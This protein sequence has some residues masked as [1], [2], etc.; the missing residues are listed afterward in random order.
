MAKPGIDVT[1]KVEFGN[2]NDDEYL[3]IKKCL[4]GKE[5]E[6]QEHMI[7][8]YPYNIGCPNCGVKLFFRHV[9]RIYQEDK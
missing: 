1:D 9:V 7:S 3:P 2:N 6:L 8:N 4:C 5:F